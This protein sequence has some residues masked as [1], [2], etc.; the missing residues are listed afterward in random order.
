[1]RNL[2]LSILIF[3]QFFILS[4]S[5]NI[6]NDAE[7]T[8]TE[9]SQ[10]DSP[11]EKAAKE[12]FQKEKTENEADNAAQPEPMDAVTETILM[13][14]IRN[15][16]MISADEYALSEAYCK[17]GDSSLYEFNNKSSQTDYH[18]AIADYTEAIKIN[19]QNENAYSSRGNAKHNH[20]D[21]KGA[22]V[23]YNMV[24]E[25]DPK[26]QWIYQSR[27]Y[28]EVELKDYQGAISD[29]SKAIEINPRFDNNWTQRGMVKYELQD[30]RGAIQDYTVA[31]G[32]NPKEGATYYYRGNAKIMLGQKDSGCLDLSKAGELGFGQAYD[33]IKKY[34]N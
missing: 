14:N 29:F 9:I 6:K 2:F 33:L 24:I 20:Q 3:S 34:C 30:Y 11:A 7:E 15:K 18:S 4:C 19:P 1:M 12:R 25:L 13:A 27:G 26:N 28:S 16:K 10:Y 23:D 5:H 21:Y 8:A 32:M 22:I 17:R 31:I